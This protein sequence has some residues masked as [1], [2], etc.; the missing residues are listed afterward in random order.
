MFSQPMGGAEVVK[1]EVKESWYRKSKVTPF[2]YGTTM[3]PGLAYVCTV[4]AFGDW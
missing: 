1:V 3:I 4:D 2:E